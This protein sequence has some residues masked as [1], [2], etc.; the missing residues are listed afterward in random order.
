MKETLSAPLQESIIALIA[1]NDKEGR[2]AAG[3]LTFEVFDEPYQ[4]FA[5]RLLEYH[6]QHGKAPGKAHLD[7]LVDDIVGNPK[8]KQHKHYIRIIEGILSQ[9]D[10]LNAKYL[11]TR[12]AEF[13]RRQALRNGL[14]EAND[15]FLQGGEDL[16]PDVEGVL[17]KTL[18]SREEVMDAG[19]FLND[20]SRSLG[21]LDKVNLAFYTGIE[22]FDNVGFGLTPGKMLLFIGGKGIG[23]SWW[24]VDIGKRCLL[25]RKKVVHITLEMSRDE[26][27]QRY[28][29]NLFAIP[30]DD[31]PYITTK[32]QFDKLRRLSRLELR[33]SVPEISLDSPNIRRILGNKI[34]KF[35]S[36]LG[37]L[38]VQEFA[39]NSLTISKLE[40]YLDYLELTAKFIPDVLLVDYPDLMFMQGGPKELRMSVGRTFQEL[41]GLLQRRN[42]A[43][44]FP[45]QGNRTSWGAKNVRA[46][47]I[48]EDA[49]K[50]MTA[51]MTMTYSQTEDEKARG[52]ARLW[53]EH[54]RGGR[55]K[56]MVLISQSYATGQFVLRSMRFPTNYWDVVGVKE[57]QE[58]SQWTTDDE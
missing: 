6:K 17:L 56:F 27:L 11:L 42:L 20:T 1:T 55:D 49:S 54:H 3:T 46:N 12:V 24:V 10:E 57:P 5:G 7:D 4:D 33:K 37:R 34:T 22:A 15:R 9:A 36:K 53:V 35:K 23:K 39:T 2:V 32:F 47:M 43:G 14:I 18:R 48:S 38:V 52:L 50:I 8:H 21:F 44:A 13:T 41:R 31:E 25:Q 26:V 45:T 29:Q 19:V 58:E 30:K 28:Y 16:V 51:D 40:A